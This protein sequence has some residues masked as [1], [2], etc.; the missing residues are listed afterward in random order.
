MLF[1]EVSQFCAECSDI[2]EG[3][4]IIDNKWRNCLHALQLLFTKVEPARVTEFMR[5]SGNDGLWVHIRREDQCRIHAGVKG[6]RFILASL[7][8]LLVVIL[9]WLERVSIFPHGS[10][11]KKDSHVGIHL[12]FF[13]NGHQVV[14]LDCGMHDC[15]WVNKLNVF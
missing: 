10:V 11:C 8:L 14:R 9:F 3:V 5:H 2:I 12:L 13:A 4:K 1:E 15:S 6:V 7:P